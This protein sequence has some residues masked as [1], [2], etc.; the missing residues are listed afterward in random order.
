MCLVIVVSATI[1]LDHKIDGDYHYNQNDNIRKVDKPKSSKDLVI[2]MHS[3][4]QMTPSEFQTNGRTDHYWNGQFRPCT[5]P[6]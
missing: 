5:D 4:H 6:C 2:S 1:A 3:G